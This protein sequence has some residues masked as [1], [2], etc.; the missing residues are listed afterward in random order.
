MPG[1]LWI[2]P[3]YISVRNGW[4][5]S[6]AGTEVMHS[7]GGMGIATNYMAWTGS[8]SDSTG[9]GSMVNLG[10]LYENTLS[11]VE[12]R[13][14]GSMLPD[15]AVSLFGLFTSA[16][17]DLPAGTTLMQNRLRQFKYGA[18]VTLQATD[19]VGFMLRGDL[20]DYDLDL[21]GYILPP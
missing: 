4:A 10:F 5:L 11:G 1:H 12:G 15:L 21:P 7:L 16:S 17:L 18:D 9:T 6:S 13:P 19:W 2:S 20:V 14:R 3:S 8:S